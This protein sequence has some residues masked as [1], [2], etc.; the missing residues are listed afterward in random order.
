M[1]SISELM[2]NPQYVSIVSTLRPY[3]PALQRMGVEFYEDVIRDAIAGDWE[4]FDEKLWVKMTEDE[5]DAASDALL[6]EAR[7][8]VDRAYER[9]Q[10]AKELAF[11]LVGSVLVAMI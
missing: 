5:R 6:A 2:A 11:K 7:D 10:L 4:T 3:I 8:A 1:M 9:D